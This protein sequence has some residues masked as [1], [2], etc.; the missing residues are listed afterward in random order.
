MSISLKDNNPDFLLNNM[1]FELLLPKKIIFGVGSVWRAGIELKNLNC[2]N[3]LIVTSHG[4]RKRDAVRN[5]IESLANQKINSSIFYDVD[6]E[7][8]IEN[9]Y[10]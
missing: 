3:G 5:V 1:Q 6:P 10:D 4:M 7:P 9:V 2:E 8:P